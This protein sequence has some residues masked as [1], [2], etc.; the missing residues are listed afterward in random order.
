MPGRRNVHRGES[1]RKKLRQAAQHEKRNKEYK[2]LREKKVERIRKAVEDRARTRQVKIRRIGSGWFPTLIQEWFDKMA[3]GKSVET[4]SYLF[5]V[6]KSAST[7]TR[8]YFEA[9]LDPYHRF[10]KHK[11]RGKFILDLEKFTLEKPKKGKR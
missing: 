1:D 10:G 6:D 7:R 9:I 5:E 8:V 3:L 4:E 2:K 11:S